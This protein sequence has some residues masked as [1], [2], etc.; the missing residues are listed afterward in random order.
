[1]LLVILKSQKSQVL[2][3]PMMSLPHQQQI[4]IAQIMNQIMHDGSTQYHEEQKTQGSHDDLQKQ[5]VSEE[6]LK[7]LEELEE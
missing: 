1:V 6:F 3:E 5:A 7:K 2:I 4:Q